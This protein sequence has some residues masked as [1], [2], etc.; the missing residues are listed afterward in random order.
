[1]NADLQVLQSV[2]NQC[3]AWL[4]HFPVVSNILQQL[5]V[6]FTHLAVHLCSTAVQLTKQINVNDVLLQGFQMWFMQLIHIKQLTSSL[7]CKSINF[8]IQPRQLMQFLQL[9]QA[10]DKPISHA[11]H[12]FWAYPRPHF[13]DIQA[14]SL[15]Q[16]S[17]LDVHC[18]VLLLHLPIASLIF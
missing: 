10:K 13:P 9:I 5:S 11:T 15:I 8:N 17:A 3:P 18:S 7:K 4:L 2:L 12:C 16:T 1:M 6:I 14:S